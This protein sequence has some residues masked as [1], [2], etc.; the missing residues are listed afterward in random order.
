MRL[1]IVIPVFNERA[2]LPTV[3]ENL[4]RVS[5]DKEI[6][7]VDD[8]S[9]DGTREYLK[10]MAQLPGEGVRVLLPRPK[11]GQGGRPAHRIS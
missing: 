5:L 9:T 11:P 8:G 3:L 7:I 4:A 6:L 2:T 10:D 1:S